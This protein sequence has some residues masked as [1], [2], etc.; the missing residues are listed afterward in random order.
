MYLLKEEALYSP[1]DPDW[2]V[3]GG[4]DHLQRRNDERVDLEPQAVN[5]RL[6]LLWS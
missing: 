2:P 4:P 3:G 1:S 5:S 6:D